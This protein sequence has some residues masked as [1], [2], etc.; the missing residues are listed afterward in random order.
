MGL[1]KLSRGGYVENFSFFLKARVCLAGWWDWGVPAGFK[2]SDL[3]AAPRYIRSKLKTW[4]TMGHRPI[5]DIKVY[6]FIS[7]VWDSLALQASSELGQGL[8]FLSQFPQ[9]NH[10]REDY[11]GEQVEWL[12]HSV[13]LLTY[14]REGGTIR[15]T[16]KCLLGGFSSAPYPWIVLWKSNQW[17]CHCWVPQ[18]SNHVSDSESILLEYKVYQFSSKRPSH[19]YSNII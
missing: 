15:Q 16:P 9:L 13:T 6:Y 12:Q 3:T 8:W 7:I 17:L 11:Q 2:T 19:F 18:K 1:L 10:G 14:I 4:Q 5:C